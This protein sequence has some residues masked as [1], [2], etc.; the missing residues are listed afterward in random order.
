MKLKKSSNITSGTRFS[1]PLIFVFVALKTTVSHVLFLTI[2]LLTHLISVWYTLSLTLYPYSLY[3]VFDNKPIDSLDLSLIYTEPD[4][5]SVLSLFYFWQQAY[6]FTWSQ[7][8]I[9]WAWCFIRTLSILFLTT[10]DLS[11]IYT[12]PDA[13]SVLSLSLFCFWQQ[14]YWFT[15]SQFDIHWAW[16]FIRTLSIWW[17]S[18]SWFC[19]MFPV[20]I[21][22]TSMSVRSFA[23]H[24]LP[25]WWAS[26]S[27]FITFKSTVFA[28]YISINNNILFIHICLCFCNVKIHTYDLLAISTCMTV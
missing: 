14:A 22:E 18:D 2:S 19:S 11:L 26:T 28:K 7:F 16:R 6:W 4:A 15:W 10:L 23:L 25:V 12:E 9:H 8:D 24:F 5:L 13:L 3:S 1:Y 21:L 17:E 27:N 20:I